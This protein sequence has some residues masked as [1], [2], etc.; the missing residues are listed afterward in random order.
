MAMHSDPQKKV[1]SEMWSHTPPLPLHTSPYVIAPLQ[2]RA[3][4][5][6]LYRSWLPLTERLIF[7]FLAFM[8]W[9]FFKIGRA[10]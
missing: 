1:K 8:S 7:F 4:L 5:K 6:W 2:L 10:S 3:H 9:Y